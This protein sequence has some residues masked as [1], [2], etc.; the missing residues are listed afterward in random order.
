M[1]TESQKKIFSRN[2][3]RL[4]DER[5]ITRADLSRHLGYPETTLANWANGINYPRIDKIQELA[6]F[7]NIKKSELIENEYPSRLSIDEIIE[8]HPALHPIRRI[9][10]I[11]ILGSIHC[12]TPIFSEENFEGYFGADPSIEG[13]FALYAYGDSMVDARIYE[14]DLVFLQKI[15]D[16]PTNGKIA[17]VV[18][19]GEATLKKV[20]FD[21]EKKQLILQPCNSKYAPI[22]YQ[23]HPDDEDLP[24]IVGEC[25]GVYHPCP[26]NGYNKNE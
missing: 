23:Y 19:D 11:P 3:T 13:D 10:P 9:R 7:F 17:A 26:E 12:G 20:F 18:I 6:D 14:G 1:A 22:V 15:Y 24:I 5:K 4:L 8:K 2:F 16:A 25:V 21:E